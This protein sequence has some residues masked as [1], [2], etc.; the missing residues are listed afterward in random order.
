MY[1]TSEKIVYFR[2]KVDELTTQFLQLGGTES[3]LD[4]SEPPTV[5]GNNNV[6]FQV[7]APDHRTGER[8]DSLYRRIRSYRNRFAEVSANKEV[9]NKDKPVEYTTGDKIKYFDNKIKDLTSRY[10]DNGGKSSLLDIPLDDA[11]NISYKHNK[12]GKT[13]YY[14][15]KQIRSYRGRL[16]Q[17]KFWASRGC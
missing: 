9:E 15:H 5:Q 8:L 3:M 4:C 12:R 10:F 2:N 13:L 11:Y 17:A 7:I 14:L 1:T 16:A 6:F